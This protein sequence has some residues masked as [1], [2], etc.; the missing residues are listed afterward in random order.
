MST[1]SPVFSA[2]TFQDRLVACPSLAAP[3]LGTKR[4]LDDSL[5]AG[6]LSRRQR[7]RAKRLRFALPGPE[8]LPFC[9]R[10][11]LVYPSDLASCLLGADARGQEYAADARLALAHANETTPSLRLAGDTTLFDLLV[12]SRA[13]DVSLCAKLMAGDDFWGL[14]RGVPPSNAVFLVA[15]ERL[16][17]GSCLFRDRSANE[18]SSAAG[19]DASTRRKYVDESYDWGDMLPGASSAPE[20]DVGVLR[21][22]QECA[23]WYDLHEGLS[24]YRPVVLSAVTYRNGLGARYV[25][26]YQYLDELA[27]LG[28]LI[29]DLEPGD[30][31]TRDGRLLTTSPAIRS[32]WEVARQYQLQSPSPP[33]VIN[34]S[35]SRSSSMSS[36]ESMMLACAPTPGAGTCMSPLSVSSGVSCPGA[37]LRASSFMSMGSQEM[38]D[39]ADCMSDDFAFEDSDV[40]AGTTPFVDADLDDLAR[41]LGE[42]DP[43]LVVPS[44]PPF[45]PAS[46]MSTLS[47][48]MPLVPLGRGVRYFPG[49]YVHDGMCFDDARLRVGR[50]VTIW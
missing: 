39:R 19:D 14:G 29:M 50:S 3:F 48:D 18:R 22:G 25:V 4:P 16:L 40:V 41:L 11:S 5:A 37:P 30:I 32:C 6:S 33:R 2:Q 21:V 9:A 13:V 7:Q 44:P 38:L 31:D 34:A 15:L 24:F 42:D 45:S 46:S 27:S 26:T 35:P 47:D 28:P 23:L 20:H 36:T 49:E 8:L 10:A 17:Q 12:C 1:P 43:D